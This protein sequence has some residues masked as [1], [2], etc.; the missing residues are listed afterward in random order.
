MASPH[1]MLCYAVNALCLLVCV[2]PVWRTCTCRGVATITGLS[3]F[4]QDVQAGS[5]QQQQQ[6]H[7][8]KSADPQPHQLLVWPDC[9]AG[10]DPLVAQALQIAEP[11]NRLPLQLS[12]LPSNMPAELLMTFQGAV[13]A[14][15]CCVRLLGFGRNARPQ[16]LFGQAPTAIS[17][18]LCALKLSCR[19]PHT[20]FTIHNR[21][22]AAG[23]GPS[24]A[25][26]C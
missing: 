7:E 6:P 4:R 11:I 19:C 17:S 22:G 21:N 1:T 5:Q 20:L 3:I 15:Q 14:C 12:V 25:E 10:E 8:A 9:D 13:S 24:N 18:T 26:G 16:L 23:A 2:L